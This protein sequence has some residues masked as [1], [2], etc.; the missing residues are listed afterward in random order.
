MFNFSKEE[1]ER[2]GNSGYEWVTGDEANMTAEKMS[3]RVIEVL[4]K[5]FDSFIP[6]KLFDFYTIEDR[7]ANYIEHKL[8][9]Y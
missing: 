5:G 7:Q 9:G 8:T 4:D 6:R 1:R 2:R 3:N